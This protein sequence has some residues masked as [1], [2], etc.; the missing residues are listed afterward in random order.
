M[1]YF[2]VEYDRTQ[3][4]ADWTEYDDREAALSALRDKEGGRKGHIE[5]VLFRAASL[6]E[7]RTTHSRY[8]MDTDEM[9]QRLTDD[10]SAASAL[11]RNPRPARSA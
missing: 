8:F 10:S 3:R 9:G 5:V 11:L 6:D 1:K 4:A 7:L 2:I